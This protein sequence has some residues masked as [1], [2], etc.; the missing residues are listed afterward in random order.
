MKGFRSWFRTPVVTTAALILAIGLLAVSGIGTARAALGDTTRDEIYTLET[1]DIG[2]TLMENGKGRTTLLNDMLSQTGNKLVLNNEYDEKLS[3]G[4]SG[5]IDEY[6]RVTIRRYW[7]DKNNEKL[8]DLKPSLIHMSLGEKDLDDAG[9]SANG[10]V[11][12]DDA[13]TEERIVLYYSS[14]VPKNGGESALFADT[15]RIDNSLATFV[16]QTP[17]ADGKTFI[18]EYKY[19]GVKFCLEVTA[20]GV[21]DHNAVFTNS[22]GD[23]DG[24]IKSAWGV[25]ASDVGINVQ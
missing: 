9:F 14:L 15:L 7:L 4:N 12:D 22:D 20:D 2:I 3:V 13:S 23:T 5:T 11:K 1:K 6:V 21:Q 25:D 10:W 17:S 24:A 16:K 8:T 19:D 18:T